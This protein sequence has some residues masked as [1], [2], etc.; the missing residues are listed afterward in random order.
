MKSTKESSTNSA[1]LKINASNDDHVP[2]NDVEDSRGA[3]NL[4]A[5]EVPLIE[6]ETALTTKIRPWEITPPPRRISRNQTPPK[7]LTAQEAKGMEDVQ[8]RRT[9]STK[10]NKESSAEAIAA[11]VNVN[12]TNTATPKVARVENVRKKAENLGNMTNKRNPRQSEVLLDGCSAEKKGLD[13]K[14]V[15]MSELLGTTSH[16]A[17]E[18]TAPKSMIS[19][20]VLPAK[21]RH[22]SNQMKLWVYSNGDDLSVYRQLRIATWNVEPFMNISVHVYGTSGR[23]HVGANPYPEYFGGGEEKRDARNGAR[24]AQERNILASIAQ[25]GRTGVEPERSSKKWQPWKYG[26]RAKQSA[27][28]VVQRFHPRGHGGYETG[29]GGR[30]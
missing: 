21:K 6:K 13:N 14:M 28:S 30:N 24:L 18:P 11:N 5:S 16:V 4:T 23:R 9:R 8:K 10:E 2:M 12:N 26:L 25:G 7:S 22:R 29:Q 27:H 20:S 17:K 15:T 1:P 19:R 3:V